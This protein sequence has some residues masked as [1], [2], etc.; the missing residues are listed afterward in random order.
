MK[1]NNMHEKLKTFVGFGLGFFL[2]IA[3]CLGMYSLFLLEQIK[4]TVTKIN[5][6]IDTNSP[7]VTSTI[8]SVRDSSKEGKELVTRVNEFVDTDKLKNLDNAVNTQI[9]SAQTLTNSYKAIADKTV[10]TLAKQVDPGIEELRTEGKQTFAELRGEVQELQKLTSEL[11]HQVNQNGDEVKLLVEQGRTLIA[12][13]EKDLLATLEN[14]NKAA[15]GIQI[16]VN[17]PALK[18][19][20][21]NAS[22]TLANIQVITKEAA[23]L[24]VHVVEPIV[25]PR[26]VTGFARFGQI[27][28]KVVR[29][30]NGAGQ[31]LFLIDRLGG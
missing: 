29:T 18:L 6:L 15:N 8:N 16:L 13:S 21:Q 25:R 17:D 1:R 23:D 11:T 3:S 27:V 4:Q 12:H 31:V 28:L 26:K 19:L 5:Q 20:I 9:Y 2:V 10:D 7:A 30:I 24:S 22:L 14:I